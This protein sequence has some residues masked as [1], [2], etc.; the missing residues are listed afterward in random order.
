IGIPPD[1]QPRIFSL[2]FS[3]K[4]GGSGV[5]LAMAYRII[6]MHNGS[7]DFTSEPNRG[8]T[9]RITLPV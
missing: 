6:Q 7:I 5:G 3:T 4:P 8:T 1:V 9:F 2:Y